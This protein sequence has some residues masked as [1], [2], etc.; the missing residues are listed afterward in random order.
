MTKI[1]RVLATTAAI[2]FLLPLAACSGGAD[3]EGDDA[4]AAEET[5]EHATENQV[6]SVI[7][8]REPDW[9]E[10]IEGRSGCK[11]LWEMERQGVADLAQSL[12]AATCFL[13]MKTFVTTVQT[14]A[15]ELDELVPPPSME[16]LV[17]DMSKVL[18]AIGGYDLDADC[19]SESI[20]A[21]TSLC[22]LML[23]G[24][25]VN[26]LRLEDELNAWGPY[27]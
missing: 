9:R 23:T 24:M 13:D 26:S 4:T 11:L 1:Q 2:L 18:S 22:D 16:M 5:V 21:D 15:I 3:A 17:A 12:G 14:A 8:K 10:F 7:A 25:D 6:A 27:L 19:G 20:P